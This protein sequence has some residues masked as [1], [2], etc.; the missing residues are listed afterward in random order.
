[1]AVLVRTHTHARRKFNFEIYMFQSDL[2]RPALPLLVVVAS[3]RLSSNTNSLCS[4]RITEIKGT[5]YMYIMQ[6]IIRPNK[7]RSTFRNTTSRKGPFLHYVVIR[8]PRVVKLKIK[9]KATKTNC[10]PDNYGVLSL[11]PTGACILNDQLKHQGTLAALPAAVSFKKP[12]AASP[13]KKK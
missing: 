7:N 3:H 4:E 5:L 13:R 1:M 2:L 10:W 6:I 8:Y 11:R 9:Y 12:G